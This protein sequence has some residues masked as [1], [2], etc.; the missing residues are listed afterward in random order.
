MIEKQCQIVSAH[1]S[2]CVTPFLLLHLKEC[3][4]SILSNVKYHV[5]FLIIYEIVLIREKYFLCV[6]KYV[7]FI[8]CDS[9]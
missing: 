3:K 6:I 1:D 4:I 9:S 7:V 8:Q 2:T 5:R